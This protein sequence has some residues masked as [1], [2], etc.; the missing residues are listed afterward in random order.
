MDKTKTKSKGLIKG[1]AV[2]F[3]LVLSSAFF[4]AHAIANAIDYVGEPAKSNTTRI[5]VNTGSTENT[6]IKSINVKKGESVTIPEGKYYV[7]NQEIKIGDVSQL[8]EDLTVSKVEV[9]YKATNDKVA[10]M[11]GN[12]FTADRVGRYS[13]VYTV[14]YKGVEYSYELT[15][16]CQATQANFEFDSNSSNIIPSVYDIAC[17]EGK[18]IILPLPTINDEDGNAILTAEDVDHYVT[19][20]AN[21]PTEGY[22]NSYVKISIVNA[23]K[24][25]TI[26][27]LKEEGSDKVIGYYIPGEKISKA[28]L[29]GQ[30]F[31][32]YYTY[33]QEGTGA[34]DVFIS[35]VS[36]TFT[37]KSNY[38]Y[39][40]ENKEETGY[41]LETSWSS[42]VSSLTAVVGVEKELPKITAKTK[43]TNSPSSES[44][45]VYYTVKVFKDGTEVTD[46]VM[47]KEGKFKATEEGDYKFVYSVSDFYGNTVKESNTTFYIEKVKDSVSATAYMYDAGDENA[48]DAGKNE[49]KSAKNIT[50]SQ[51][52]NRNIIM[53]AIGGTDNNPNA[54][55]T[56]RRE[57]RDNS[58]VKMFVIEEKLYNDYN[59]IFAPGADTAD[60]TLDEIY[61]QIP[62]DNYEIYKQMLMSEDGQNNPTDPDD[63]KAFLTAHKYL[64]V[65]TEENK[66]NGELIEG[67]EE[68][69][70]YTAEDYKNAGFAYI[71][72]QNSKNSTFKFQTY[73]FYYYASDGVNTEKSTYTT[74]KV[75]DADST[76]AEVPTLTFAS[77]L[78][79]AYLPTD[80]FEFDV[81]TANDTVDTRI[82]AVTAYRF[83]DGNKRA[84]EVD[85][86]TT[87]L[88][89]VVKNAKS[90]AW[91]AQ[92]GLMDENVEEN[93][94]WFVD[95]TKSSY[96]I[97]LKTRPDGANYVEI[98]AYSI[99]DY[100]N[101]GFYNKVIKIADADDV[102]MPTIYKVVNAPAG[103]THK[104]PET[105][106]LPTLYFA[107]DNVN[108]MHAS[109]AVYKINKD[110]TRVR[111]Q[112]SNMTTEY[113][114]NADSFKLD[115][116]SFH[117]S[118]GGNYQVAIT[119]IDSGYH[120][121]TTYFDYKVVGNAVIQ[122]P[123]INNIKAETVELDAGQAYYLAPPT[124][125]MPEVDENEY[126]FIGISEDDSKTATNY[127]TTVVSATGDY[128]L[129]QYYFVGNEKGLFKLQYKV[130]LMQYSK[131]EG[132]LASSSATATNGKI[133]FDANGS[134][135]FKYA[136]TEYFVN[137]DRYN[138]DPEN[139]NPIIANTSKQGIGSA[140]STEGLNALKNIVNAYSI[141]SKIQ[142]INVGGVEMEVTLDDNAYA[143]SYTT[144]GNKIEVIK[145]TNITF[146]G[147]SYQT[148]NKDSKVTIT[149]KTGG[150]TTTLAEFSFEEWGAGIAD[151][152]LGDTFEVSDNDQEIKLVLKDNGQYTI[153]YSIQAMDKS[154][155]NVGSAKTMEYTISNGDVIPP[156]VE[157]NS[158]KLVK[159]KYKINDTLN[160]DLAGISVSDLGTTDVDKLLETM[161]VTIENTDLDDGEV[162]I[163]PVEEESHAYSYKLT[164][165]GSYVLRISVTDEAGN[166]TTEKV[167]FEVVT[168]S[169]E[170][171][172]GAG[173]WVGGVL[174]GISVA[175]LV[176]VVAYFV[177]SKVK[178]DKKEK[179]YRD[180]S[181]K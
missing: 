38:Y 80:S 62:V 10:D 34:N 150:S 163:D 95:Q 174:I 72:P 175:L 125:T 26:E 158:T 97:D 159:A 169:S 116:G 134:L 103:E 40:D 30:E 4:P 120:S 88:K 151:S 46:Q 152:S 144:L 113:D 94:G 32:I 63:V 111:M 8:N 87:S 24:D 83:L 167:N 141:E 11:V 9:F 115:A 92:T 128:Q 6:Q 177:V 99:D 149:K 78:Q 86:K 121:V 146:N 41:A 114:L 18:D 65:T 45:V 130:Y 162:E 164:S 136:D 140:L 76:D 21:L 157:I 13:I 133:F 29:N 60:A 27:P 131:D 25:V 126:G 64:L 168:E 166:K 173:A 15:V 85:G 179:S 154:G 67:M 1:V 52:V 7:G 55:I 145:P 19:D 23:G 37:V 43:S 33:Y 51:T 42:S 132:V 79:V 58:S 73:S 170:D 127:T 61:T 107:D 66:F 53:Y 142:T 84:I 160:L 82:E 147:S 49:Y 17:A 74:V 165:A 89:Y 91:Y 148:N 139:T 156:E 48:Y 124:F 16:N 22:K 143:Q 71:K 110:G 104:A 77:D 96:T 70:T 106:T 56:L 180:S 122:I 138:A 69:E 47:T 109:V 98:L 3:A 68:G 178:L 28:E 171:S 161:K 102:Q 172:E 59:L 50:K 123:E 39:T 101:A 12:T 100:G 155:L 35:S 90:T 117:A 44:V 20:T 57:I 31:K 119:V 14:V 105:I 108:Y 36:K 93:K 54:E 176:G 129:D 137:I 153:K 181:S 81:A 75:T 135:K 2:G 5:E 118:V 112:S